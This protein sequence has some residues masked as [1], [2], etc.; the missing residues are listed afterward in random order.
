VTSV[1]YTVVVRWCRW[2]CR[3]RHVC[4]KFWRCRQ[5]ICEQS[6]CHWQVCSE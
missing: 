6:S 3:W 1:L 5:D 2:S 4:E